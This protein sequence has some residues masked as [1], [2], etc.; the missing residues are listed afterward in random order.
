M[1]W[2]LSLTLLIQALDTLLLGGQVERAGDAQ[3]V[4]ENVAA[5]FQVPLSIVGI[6]LSQQQIQ[7][8]A[9]HTWLQ[10]LARHAESCQRLIVPTE[11]REGLG[12]LDGDAG[13][14]RSNEAA[15]GGQIPFA[16]KA[17]SLLEVAQALLLPALICSG[18]IAES[19]PSHLEALAFEGVT[20]EVGIR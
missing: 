6:S 19:L 1:Q 13:Q 11:H 4:C 12:L 16:C 8:P 20:G 18:H 15:V 2:G 3:G 17:G 5:A 14:I 10:M 7:L 9:C